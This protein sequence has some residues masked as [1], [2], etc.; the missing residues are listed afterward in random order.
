MMKPADISDSEN[1]E[2]GENS[3]GKDV[4]EDK[5]EGV[6]EGNDKK[7][8]EEI[9]LQDAILPNLKKENRTESELVLEKKKQE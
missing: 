4:D 5:K 3:K 7:M 2:D 1:I 9:D 6:V 8:E